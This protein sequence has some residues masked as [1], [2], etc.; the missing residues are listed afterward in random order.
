[1]SSPT[2]LKTL[3]RFDLVNVLGKGAMGIVYEGLDPR[4]GRTVAIKTIL[5]NQLVDSEVADDYSARFIREAQAVA[6]LT[7]PNIVTVFD[8]GDENDVAYIVMEFIRGKELKS[9]FDTNERFE[10]SEGVRIMCELLDA[11]DYAHQHGIVHR[12]VKPA[13]VM[14]DANARVKLT[15]FGVARVTDSNERTQAGTMVG[16]PSYMSPEQITGGKVDRRADIFSAGIILYQFLTGQKPF[17]GA[18]TWTIQKKIVNEDPVMPSIHSPTISPDFDKVIRKALAKA[19]EDR[20]ARAL[21]FAADLKRVLA[22]DPL[23]EEDSTHVGFGAARP[24]FPA[25][26]DSGADASGVRSGTRS[27][28]GVASA[29]SATSAAGRTRR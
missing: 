23:V 8:F 17:T 13:N 24:K 10:V 4:L 14:L 18:G 1:M 28:T 21:D 22:G 15:D 26:I 5:K 29:T 7:H 3:G 2:P 6:R 20:Y 12:D 11:L 19:P 9:Y 25:P 27:S 16:T